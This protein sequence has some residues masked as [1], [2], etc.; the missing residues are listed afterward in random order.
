[1]HHIIP[2]SAEYMYSWKGIGLKKKLTPS[3]SGLSADQQSQTAGKCRKWL[4]GNQDSASSDAP[5]ISCRCLENKKIAIHDA[6][7]PNYN[8]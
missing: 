3:N 7:I 1:M 6:Y 4:R 8:L 2:G 5:R